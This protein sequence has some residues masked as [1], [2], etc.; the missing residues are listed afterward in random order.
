MSWA[1]YLFH[2]A[3]LE[4]FSYPLPV[5][6]SLLAVRTLIVSP[7]TLLLYMFFQ[8]FAKQFD[9]IVLITTIMTF[10]YIGAW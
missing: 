7:W 8:I 9:Y 4:V 3:F 1:W 2:G 6:P 5:L 10:T